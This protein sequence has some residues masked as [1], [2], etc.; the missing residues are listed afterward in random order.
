MK[1][2]L[3]M[4]HICPHCGKIHEAVSPAKTAHAAPIDGD[5]SMCF[6]C[7]EWSVFERGALRLPN[8]KEQWFIATDQ[9]CQRMSI[10]WKITKSTTEGNKP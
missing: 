8:A 2:P 1:M 4:V 5:V 6:A 3:H 10:V 9:T 7:G